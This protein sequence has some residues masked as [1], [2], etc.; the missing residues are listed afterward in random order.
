MSNTITI[1]IKEYEK[2]RNNAIEYQR[3]KTEIYKLIKELKR[4]DIPVTQT[5]NKLKKLLK[6]K[7]NFIVGLIQPDTQEYYRILEITLKELKT[8]LRGSYSKWD[9]KDNK[10]IPYFRGNYTE[11]ENILKKHKIKFTLISD[12]CKLIL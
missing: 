7:N 4:F 9:K 1:N 6:E 11:F 12:E 5:I 3:L 8:I 10:P 2:L